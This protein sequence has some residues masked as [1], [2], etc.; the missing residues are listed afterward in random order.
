MRA[1]FS[2]MT[3]SPR[4][5]VLISILA[6]ASVHAQSR[7]ASPDGRNQ[8][9]VEIREGRLV[10]AVTRDGRALMLPSVL[11]FEFNSAPRLR[12]SLRVTDTTRQ[13]VDETWTQPWGE[14]TRVRN[15]HN[16]LKVSVAET[17]APNRRFTV[18]FR[19]FN[20]G[21]AFRYE[22][23]AQPNLGDFEIT[24]ELTEFALADN[25]RAWWIASNRPRLDRSEQLYS[26]GPVSTLDSV[27][28]PLTIE[29]SSGLHVV[30]HEADLVDYPR[31]F[32]A[33]PRMESRTLRAALA[34]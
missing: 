23:P 31:M 9:A 14:V 32:L 30:I 33:G 8:I 12:D 7:V 4:L 20:D 13:S 10:Y 25:G 24:N 28:T 11:G 17:A 2:P 29:M 18:A 3:L 34:P 6:P 22:F 16:E 26:A 1:T 15:H 27:Q 21:V 19:A 5:F